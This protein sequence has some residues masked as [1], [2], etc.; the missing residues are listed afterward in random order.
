MAKRG[1]AFFSSVDLALT[2]ALTAGGWVAGTKVFTALANARLAKFHFGPMQIEMILATDTLLR[3]FLQYGFVGCVVGIF[4][5]TLCMKRHP[6]RHLTAT[7]GLIFALCFILPATKLWLDSEG[8]F[9]GL[10]LGGALACPIRLY[11]EQKR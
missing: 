3:E 7:Y 10:V 1:Q 9:W 5:A 11:R 4:I 2:L 6:F 8:I